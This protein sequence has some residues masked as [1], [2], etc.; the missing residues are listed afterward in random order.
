NLFNSLFLNKLYKY[1]I[2]LHRNKSGHCRGSAAKIRAS[3]RSPVSSSSGLAGRHRDRATTLMHPIGRHIMKHPLLVAALVAVAVSAC[4]KKDEPAAVQEPV[5]AQE[6]MKE[7][8]AQAVDAAKESAQAAG[9]AAAAAATAAGE[10]ATQLG[11]K[12]EAAAAE[13]GAAAQ[14]L[15]QDATE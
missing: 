13:A 2:F 11:E 7:S 9:D 1:I 12:A 8:A 10:A 14:E 3:S 6:Q 15:K 5:S 4:G